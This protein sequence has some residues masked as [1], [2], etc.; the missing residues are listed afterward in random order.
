MNLDHIDTRLCEELQHDGRASMES[1]ASVVGLSRVAAGARVA[2]LIDSGALRIIG[3]VHPSALGLRVAAHLSISVSGSARATGQ[4]IAALNSFPLVSVVA[5][6]A[7][8]IAEVYATNMT[9]LRALIR[10]VT[11]MQNVAHVEA[12]V[13]T[14]RIKDLYA[15]PG[16]IPPTEI[17]NVDRQVL[18]ALKMNGRASYA[19]IARI[20][21]FSASAIRGRVNQLT[22]RGV[23][24]ISAVLTPGMVGLQHMCGFGLHLRG[25]TEYESVSIIEAMESV[26]YLSLTLSRFDAIGTMLAKSQ[27]DVVTELD[28][29]RSTPGVEGLE[30]WTHLEVVKENHLLTTFKSTLP[31]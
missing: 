4:N 3:I 8:L 9:A 22:S 6:R 11:A 23:V 7:A 15:P 5:G 24:R 19:E 20:T 1:L 21:N 10:V 17:D 25:G 18:E 31:A 30:S 28:R 12:A 2:R 29:I 16:V 27:A 13:Y 26:S 14:E